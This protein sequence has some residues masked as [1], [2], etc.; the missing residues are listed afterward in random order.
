LLPAGPHLIDRC[1]NPTLDDGQSAECGWSSPDGMQTFLVRLHKF[2]Y[3][4]RFGGHWE[5]VIWIATEVQGSFCHTPGEG[6]KQ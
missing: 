3:L 1:G 5:H 4:K 6:E 2:D